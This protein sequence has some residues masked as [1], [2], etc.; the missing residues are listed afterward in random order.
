MGLILFLMHG[1]KIGT[2]E[3]IFLGILN[4][5]EKVTNTFSVKADYPFKS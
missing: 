3:N 1:N 5:L 4:Q 2:E